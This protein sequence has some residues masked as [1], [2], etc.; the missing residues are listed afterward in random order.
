M[1]IVSG[2]GTVFDIPPDRFFHPL[3]DVMGRSIPYDLSGFGDVGVGVADVTRPEV[4]VDWFLVDG[5]W[6]MVF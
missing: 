5:R 3:I 1:S 2:I 6:Q 4:P